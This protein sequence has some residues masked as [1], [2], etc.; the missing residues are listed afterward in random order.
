MPP[1]TVSATAAATAAAV[2]QRTLDKL[3]AMQDKGKKPSTPAAGKPAPAGKTKS[4]TI[5]EAK[6]AAASRI[7]QRAKDRIGALAPEAGAEEYDDVDMVPLPP[8]SAPLAGAK[9]HADSPADRT[10][11]AG[12][13]EKRRGTSAGVRG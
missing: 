13:V 4:P 6:L 3:A 10:A 2:R 9:R 11:G 7:A 1:K 8:P 12:A 5:S